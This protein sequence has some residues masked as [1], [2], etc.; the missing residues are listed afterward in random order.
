MLSEAKQRMIVVTTK[1]IRLYLLA[2]LRHVLSRIVDH[3]V[4]RVSELV[5]RGR[6]GSISLCVS[7]S[8]FAS[9]TASLA[10]THAGIFQ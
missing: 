7:Q 2:Y 6:C 3:P 9:G 10:R 1:L 4:N 8:R 5:L